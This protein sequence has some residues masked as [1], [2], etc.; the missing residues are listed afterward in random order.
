[1]EEYVENGVTLG[2]LID[3]HERKV[4]VYR[5]NAEVEALEN[6]AEISGGSL[7]PGFTLNLKEIRE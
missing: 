2:W 3:P 5:P 7:L 1:M 6:S 4:Y